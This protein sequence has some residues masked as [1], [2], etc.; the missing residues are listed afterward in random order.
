MR[1]KLTAE[2]SEVHA[3]V[4]NFQLLNTYLP[5][6]FDSAIQEIEQLR[7][8]QDTAQ[9]KLDEAIATAQGNKI[10]IIYAHYIHS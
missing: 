7:L 1:L 2:L 9:Y 4:D 6:Q 3:S 8:T 5:S 10:H